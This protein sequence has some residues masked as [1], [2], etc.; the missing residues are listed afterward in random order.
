MFDAGVS[1]ASPRGPL[2]DGSDGRQARLR[3]SISHQPST[4]RGGNRAVGAEMMLVMETTP[5]TF[6]TSDTSQT[7]PERAAA[8][9]T[10]PQ[11]RITPPRAPH[12]A[13]IPVPE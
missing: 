7:A 1:Y 3:R 8:P 2:V 9:E 11:R 12:P 13:D 6:S 10:R 4:R 5:P